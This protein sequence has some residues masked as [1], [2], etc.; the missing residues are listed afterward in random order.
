MYESTDF[1]IMHNLFVFN[2]DDAIMI[3]LMLQLFKTI[4]NITLLYNAKKILR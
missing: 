4:E 3:L 1:P 2:G